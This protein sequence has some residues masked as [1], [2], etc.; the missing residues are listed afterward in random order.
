[1][2]TVILI[3]YFTEDEPSIL[4]VQPSDNPRVIL[5]LVN[6]HGEDDEKNSKGN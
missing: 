6:N 2:I 1:M 3:N 4:S 5:E